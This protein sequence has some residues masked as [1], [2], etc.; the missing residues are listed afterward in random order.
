MAYIQSHKHAPDQQPRFKRSAAFTALALAVPGVALAQQEQTLSTVSVTAETE[1]FKADTAASTKYTAPLVDTPKTLT[2][3]TKEVLQQTNA[4]TLQ[5]ALRT[6]PGITFGM[7]EG[8][9]PAG[10]IPI[11]RGF[12]S[13]ANFFIDGLRD[14]SSQ[15]RDMFAVEQVDVTKG[16]DSAYSGGGAVGGSITT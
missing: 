6:T 2:V 7:G 5:D 16:P 10:D 15:S 14:P 8:G 13:E 9:T 12:K 3:I 1:T 11:I 4:T